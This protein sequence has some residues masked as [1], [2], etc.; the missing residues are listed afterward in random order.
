MFLLAH[1]SDPHLGSLP[2]PRLSELAGKRAIGFFNWIRKRRAS[3]REDVVAALIVDMKSFAPDHIA[4]T[5]DLINISLEAEYAPA[6]LWL[7]AIGSPENVTVVPGNHD[8]YVGATASHSGRHWG[9]FM[10]GD[11]VQAL[12]GREISYPFVRRRGPVALIGLSTAVPSSPFTATGR[13][14]REQL[15]RLAQL[16]P[17][18]KREG[19]YRVVLVHH[20]PVSSPA[21]R[22]RRLVDAAEF[23]KVLAEHGAELVLHGHNHVHSLV[24]LDG[25]GHRIPAFGVPSASSPPGG[26]HQPAGYNLYRIAGTPGAW[27]CEAISRSLQPDGKGFIELARQKLSEAEAPI[28][29]PR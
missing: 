8:A 9:D 24:W 15:T 23:R 5:G 29:K 3:H 7:A 2:R 18:I 12:V 14:G 22:L 28:A 27:Q 17:E 19:L 21:Q 13:L 16:L 25:P 6:R 11:A 1:L 26:R 20:P 10:S 4:V